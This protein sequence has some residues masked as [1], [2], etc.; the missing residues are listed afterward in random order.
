MLVRSLLRNSPG[1]SIETGPLGKSLLKNQ[2]TLSHLN[3]F[4]EYKKGLTLTPLRGTQTQPPSQRYFS[5]FAAARRLFC[6]AAI[7][8]RASGFRM[9]LFE[10]KV[11]VT[12]FGRPG[13]RFT[14]SPLIPSARLSRVISASSSEIWASRSMCVTFVDSGNVEVERW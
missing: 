2:A 7:F 13:P 11:L 5:F 4:P 3:G 6:A 10:Y 8:A 14:G 1:T 9:L 12:P